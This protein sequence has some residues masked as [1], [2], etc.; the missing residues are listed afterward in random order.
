M[1]K[2]IKVGNSRIKW[3]GRVPYAYW[4]GNPD[5]APW[6]GELMQCNVT[7]QNDWNSRLYVQ[8]SM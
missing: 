4:K 5:V 3:E 1:L 8:V 2:D 6:R 7:D